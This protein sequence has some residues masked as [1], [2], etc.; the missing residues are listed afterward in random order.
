[1]L[2]KLLWMGGSSRHHLVET[3]QHGPLLLVHAHGRLTR[4]M[5]LLLRLPYHQRL[6]PRHLLLMLL[7]LLLLL[8]QLLL[9]KLLLLLL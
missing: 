6:T 7:L 4:H 3:R 9:R 5:V 1:M 8:R 2:L